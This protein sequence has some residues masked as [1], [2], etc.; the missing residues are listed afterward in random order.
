MNPVSGLILEYI[1][2]ADLH[3]IV[4]VCIQNSILTEL[5]GVEIQPDLVRENSCTGT[6]KFQEHLK[7]GEKKR[8]LAK[9]YDTYINLGDNQITCK[10][11]G[12]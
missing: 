9:P 7:P 3:V 11:R 5:G 6:R 12:K 8:D 1:K 10:T 4:D 2:I